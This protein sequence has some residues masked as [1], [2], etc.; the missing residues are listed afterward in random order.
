[1][2]RKLYKFKLGYCSVMCLSLFA[3]SHNPNKAYLSHHAAVAQNTSPANTEIVKTAKADPF[4]LY[5]AKQFFVE[6]KYGQA[7][8]AL[9]PLAEQG[10]ADAQYGI[11]YLYYYGKGIEADRNAGVRWIKQSAHQGFA[12]A[13]QA[14][15]LLNVEEKITTTAAVNSTPNSTLISQDDMASTATDSTASTATD[16]TASDE[17]NKAEKPAQLNTTTHDSVATTTPKTTNPD[18]T[19]NNT[20][21]IMDANDD[22]YLAE[23]DSVFYKQQQQAE[24]ALDNSAGLTEITLADAEDKPAADSPATETPA[25][26]TTPEPAQLSH[27]AKT[28]GPTKATDTLWSIAKTVRPSQSVPVYD[29]MMAIL[30]NNPDAFLS[31]ADVNSLKLDSMLKIPDVAEINTN[32]KT[33]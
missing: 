7:F 20:T 17:A 26:A 12:S 25:P 31:S 2:E 29:M 19:A 13:V 11:G 24:Q 8:K 3:C 6:K 14:L 33:R 16:S 15:K 18:V 28:Y 23:E 9:L 5:T 10:D 1:M 21:E 4:A 30:R 32:T 27:T 22:D